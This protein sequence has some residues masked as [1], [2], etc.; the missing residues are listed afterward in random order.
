MR[1]GALVLVWP[2]Y[3]GAQ[4]VCRMERP[5]WLAQH[6]PCQQYNVGLPRG[7]YLFRLYRLRDKADSACRH[8]N[9]FSNGSRKGNLESGTGRNFRIGNQGPARAIDQIDPDIFKLSAE[10][11]GL[12]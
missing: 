10:F 1:F 5:V 2:E 7:D 11:D 8:T 12:G 3:I 4:Y 6:L 9:F